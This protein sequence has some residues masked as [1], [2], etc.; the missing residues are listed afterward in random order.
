MTLGVYAQQPYKVYIYCFPESPSSQRL[1]RHFGNK[2]D[3]NI[4]VYS[5]K[6]PDS[7]DRFLKIV[8]TLR[9]LAIQVMPP[10]LCIPCELQHLE[11]NDVLMSYTS[12]LVGFFRN[13]KLTAIT[14]GITQLEILDIACATSDNGV[15]VFTYSNEHPLNDEIVA[16]SLQRLLLGD[17]EVGISAANM[18]TPISLLALADSINPCTF[19]VFTAL[20]LIALHS[21]GKTKAALTGFSFIIAIFV[22][23]YILG[24]GLIRILAAVP[25]VDEAVALI[26]LVMG[27]FSITQG[28][29]P[30]FRSPVPK[31]LKAFIEL[32]ISKAYVSPLASFALGAAASFILL[33]CSSGPYVVGVGLL[34]ILK[35]PVQVQLLLTLY[36][37][38]F[39]LPL[40][41]ILFA[42][43]FS[44]VY[45]RKVKAFRQ[46]KLGVMELISGL[47]LVTMCIYILLS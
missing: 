20:L 5:L 28:L 3:W 46:K 30:N 22:C 24:L 4:I 17:I 16:V 43:L 1:L 36:N 10:E 34:S 41:A 6:D 40:I 27:A 26:G 32:Q 19:A 29:K 21:L 39:V 12:P 18:V 9:L 47:I 14:V 15:T 44:S 13:G 11:W 35:D 33:P 31:F 42:V 45:A 2:S 25:Y 38:I 8:E 23:Y 7:S 37:A